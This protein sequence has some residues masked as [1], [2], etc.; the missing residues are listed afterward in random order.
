MSMQAL[1]DVLGERIISSDTWPARSPDL[2]LC[3]FFFLG[4]FEGQRLQQ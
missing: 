4:L 1:S 2:N 3:E